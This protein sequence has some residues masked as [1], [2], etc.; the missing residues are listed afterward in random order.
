MTINVES[1]SQVNSVEDFQN[2]SLSVKFLQIEPTTRCNFNCGFCCGRKMDQNDLSW[3]T[4]VKTLEAFPDLEHIELHG[5]GEPL[6]NPHFFEMAKLARDKGIT[7]SMISNG[8]WLSQENIEKILDSRIESMLVSIES[9]NVEDFK[10]IRHGNLNQVI[11]GI[12]SLLKTRNKRGQIYPTVGF[13]VTVLQRTKECLPAI[14][15]LYEKLG[16]D[17]GISIHPLNPMPYY[18]EV[19][20]DYITGQLLSKTEQALVWLRYS[21][22]AK[23]GKY[24]KKVTHFYEKV[25]GDNVSLMNEKDSKRSLIK[26]YRSCPWLDNGLYVDRHGMAT[27]C[28][29]IK[30]TENF[31]FGKIG[32][33]TN[34]EIIQNRNQMGD[35]VRGGIIPA[36]CTNCF[37]AESIE[38]RLSNLLSQKPKISDLQRLK[39][40]EWTNANDGNTIG[41]VPYDSSLVEFVLD[42]CDGKTT[43]KIMIL[44]FSQNSK[45]DIKQSQIQ[46]LPVINQL[47][48]QQVI[49]IS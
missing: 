44:K 30:N 13:S 15:K 23:T 37:I 24:D 45:I 28:P 1:L 34:S 14:A 43:C 8:S 25:F 4:F 42:L 32:E 5:E 11:E 49:T 18:Q 48:H 40:E 20:N 19:Y 46:V 26:N 35:E 27:G 47:I 21:K 22:L 41:V 33:N 2:S 29:R 7:V 10:E 9:P 31:A 12:D 6:L 16:M 3:E 39:P 17:G 36:A 38:P